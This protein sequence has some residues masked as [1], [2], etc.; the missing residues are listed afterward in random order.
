MLKIWK[1]CITL[2]SLEVFMGRYIW[3]NNL[4]NDNEIHLS[5]IYIAKKQWYPILMHFWQFP[6]RIFNTYVFR[7]KRLKSNQRFSGYPYSQIY[8]KNKNEIYTLV[9]YYVYKLFSIYLFW[10]KLLEDLHFWT[11]KMAKTPYNGICQM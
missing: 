11:P 5:I 2:E 1:F 4:L 9:S 8:K 7:Q 6:F 10:I 3:W